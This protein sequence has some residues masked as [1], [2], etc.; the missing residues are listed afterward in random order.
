MIGYLREHVLEIK[1]G[2]ARI[3]EAFLESRNLIDFLK[4]IQA[5][6]DRIS[7]FLADHESV[8]KSDYE[9][10]SRKYKDPVTMEEEEEEEDERNK[11]EPAKEGQKTDQPELEGRNRKRAIRPRRVRKN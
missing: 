1:I 11:T 6:S 4:V 5:P 7:K 2:A 3:F 8:A 9:E 10:L